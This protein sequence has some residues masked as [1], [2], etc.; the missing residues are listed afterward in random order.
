MEVFA[1][2]NHCRGHLFL[3]WASKL[4]A[5]LKSLRILGR[6]QKSVPRLRVF[7][8]FL[9]VQSPPFHSHRLVTANTIDEKI[10][11]RAAAKRRLEKLVIHQKKFKSQD[12]S[13]LKTTME[14]ISPSELLSLLNSKDHAGVVDRKDGMIFTQEELDAL[15]DRS[16]LAWKKPS[17]NPGKNL[18]V[19]HRRISTAIC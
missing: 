3:L 4:K 17:E 14:A 5:F 18:T 8:G 10:V 9:C 12:L 1:I 6:L 15:L 11:E 13:G 2:V 7:V 19:F 16:E